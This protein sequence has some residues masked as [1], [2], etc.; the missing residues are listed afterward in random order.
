M[1]VFPITCCDRLHVFRVRNR[2]QEVE[3]EQSQGRF[4]QPHFL[5]A[6]G[7]MMAHEGRLCRLDCK[8]GRRS[9]CATEARKNIA[10]PHCNTFLFSRW[11]AYP[12]LS[13]CGWSTGG[14]FIQT[15]T[16]RCWWERTAS[17]PWSLTL[18]LRKTPAHTPASQAIKQ[19]RAP[20]VWSCRL[21]VRTKYDWDFC[22]LTIPLWTFQLY[23]FVLEK[24]RK[25]PPQFVE[26]LQNMGIPEG[27]PVRLECRVVGMPPPVIFWKKDNETIPR[28]KD[29]IRLVR[30]LTP[31]DTVSEPW[32]D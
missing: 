2:I 21:W 18:S 15:F 22:F 32:L 7:D 13:S 9:P 27:A 28:T 5:Q 30:T 23:I 17:I 19:G 14:P 1:C 6:P 16:T 11:A 3:G 8:V 29:R 31:S 4:F 12:T 25:H 24:E 20:S 26:K 10:S